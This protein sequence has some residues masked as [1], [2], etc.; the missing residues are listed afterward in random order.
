MTSETRIINLMLSK[1]KHQT[2]FC[3]IFSSTLAV[4]HERVNCNPNTKSGSSGLRCSSKS[5]ATDKTDKKSCLKLRFNK[6]KTSLS[7]ES[8]N[9]NAA[10]TTVSADST[11]TSPL[12]VRPTHFPS[13]FTLPLAPS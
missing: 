3:D 10:N 6:V 12:L 8:K 9:L 13:S 2:T 5:V 4:Q 7:L 1:V 11:T